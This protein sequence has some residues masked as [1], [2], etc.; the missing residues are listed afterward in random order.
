MHP[1]RLRAKKPAPWKFGN[2][3]T[4]DTG[5]IT[6]IWR[7]FQRDRPSVLAL[8]R[9]G[10]AKVYAAARDPDKIGG[11]DRVVPIRLDVADSV[12]VEAAAASCQDVNVLINNAGILSFSTK[13]AIVPLEGTSDIKFKVFDSAKPKEYPAIGRLFRN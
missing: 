9:A 11:A 8:L 4:I 13:T 5:Q 3:E 10:A 12:Q 7:A 6:P 2:V 1:W